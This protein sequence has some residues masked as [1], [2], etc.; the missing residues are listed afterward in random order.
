MLR[1]RVKAEVIL[2]SIAS[3]CLLA[4][5]L[6]AAT[7]MHLNDKL[8]LIELDDATERGNKVKV[9]VRFH[10]QEVIGDVNW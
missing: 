3:G 4:D 1:I 9:G 6:V 10:F 8:G 5:Q 7:E 2:T